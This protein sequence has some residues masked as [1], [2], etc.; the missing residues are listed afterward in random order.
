MRGLIRE[1]WDSDVDYNPRFFYDGMGGHLQSRYSRRK[2]G[3]VASG[4]AYIK[5]SGK[6]ET[7]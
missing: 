1:D 4:M 7:P 5:P 3:R 2:A 6:G